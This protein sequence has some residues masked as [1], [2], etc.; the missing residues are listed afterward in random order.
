MRAS[1][2]TMLERVSI[3]FGQMWFAAF[4]SN[5]KSSAVIFTVT[6]VVLFDMQISSALSAFTSNVYKEFKRME[7]YNISR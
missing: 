6:V 4:D 7:I 2:S 5:V 3:A 1:P